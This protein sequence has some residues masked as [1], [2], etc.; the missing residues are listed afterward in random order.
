MPAISGIG[1][2]T[3]F[4]PDLAQSHALPSLAAER[5]PVDQVHTVWNSEDPWHARLVSIHRSAAAA[6]AAAS[7]SDDLHY[8]GE[9]D[10]FPLLP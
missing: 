9:H 5:G 6:A 4:T 1:P 3:P 10:T 2:V 7:A 8:G